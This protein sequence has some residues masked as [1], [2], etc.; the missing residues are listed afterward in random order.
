[1]CSLSSTPHHHQTFHVLGEDV[2]DDVANV[3]EQMWKRSVGL[4]GFLEENEEGVVPQEKPAF[5]LIPAPSFQNVLD[6]LLM[7]ISY[8]FPGSTVFGGIASTVS[9]LSRARLFLYDS[10]DSQSVSIHAD[11]CV[12]IGMVG[13]IEVKTMVAQGT[14]PVG[15][16]YR[17]V[18]GQGSTINAIVLDEAATQEAQDSADDEEDDDDDD[19]EETSTDKNAISAAAYAKA[20]IPKPPLA[21]A[22]F[23][24]RTLS[25]DDSAFMRKA[26][27]V[28]LERGGSMGRTPN[29]LARL[30]EGKGHRFTV[31]Q[32]ASAGMKD[33]SV[34]LPL[35]TYEIVPGMRVRFFVRESEFSKK[36][37]QAL[38]T[39]YKKKTLEDTLLRMSSSDDD[40]DAVPAK[41]FE[42]AMCFLMS[43]LD[44]GSKFFGGKPG[45]ESRKISEFVPAMPCIGGFCS[46][47][48][49]GELDGSDGGQVEVMVHGSAST[50]VLLGSA[51]RR[52]IYSAAK[53][54]AD[55][56][57]DAKE[58]KEALEAEQVDPVKPSGKSVSS[59]SQEERAPR[60]ENGE[61][62]LK[63]REVHS[64]RA[65]TVSTVEWSVAE[66]MAT[67]TSTLEGYMWDKETEVDRFRERVP[68]SN[69]VS[70][71]RLSAVDLSMPKPRDWIGPVVRKAKE[72][73]FVIIPECKRFEPSTGTL[74]K[75][76]DV[77]KLVRQFVK[78]GAPAMAVNCDSVI[79]GGNLEDLTT[80]REASAKAALELATEDGMEVPPILASDLILY[81]Y[82][83][84]KMRLAGTDAVNLVGGALASKDMLYLTKIASSLQIQVLVTVTSEVQIESL[85]QLSK[86][87][88]NGLIV[89][90]REL[91][92][93]SFDLTGQQALDLLN[94]S[95]MVKFREHFGDDLPVLVEGRV[96]LIERTGSDGK[97][98][99]QNYMDELKSAGALG[100]IIGGGLA[101]ESSEGAGTALL[102]AGA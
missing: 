98:T 71:C 81:P 9:S 1:M 99:Y 31:S 91:E 75:R 61:L 2:P 29:E 97:T 83:L 41:A 43:T 19:D 49:I 84:Y 69:L 89:S 34:T 28:G 62:L 68:L 7:G 78:F 79:F 10:S 93:F 4:G 15:G 74:R 26:I 57:R 33:G 46:N 13:D 55:V 76:Y 23:V 3:P 64:G 90:N 96:G 24:M 94:S 8:K 85:L 38:W 56:A 102:Q 16:I 72:D 92:D 54:A 22:N 101:V 77:A 42:P 20:A 50:Y 21:E 86:G 48:A 51:S 32:V 70:Q 35:G 59:V 53:A 65:L 6:D 67:P 87:G 36:E 63:R 5:F 60:A 27:L 66:N 30:A 88:I 12:G 95:A 37:V 82:Q 11:G 18:A 58:A 25:D 47:G 73:G 39:G 17:V 100:A 52:P 44:R 40:E 80:A 45:Y 14:K